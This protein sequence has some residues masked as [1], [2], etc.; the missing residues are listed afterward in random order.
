LNFDKS[1]GI[2][3]ITFTFPEE[4]NTPVSYTHEIETYLYEPNVSL[5]KAGFYKGI[6]HRYRLKKLHP[7]SHLYTSSELCADFPGRIFQVEAVSSLNRQEVK[8]Y[9]PAMEKANI[10]IRNFPLSVV[11]LRKKWKWKEGG[12]IYLFATTLANNKHVLIK[13][14]RIL[15]PV[16]QRGM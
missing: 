1:E 6:A 7:D 3:M 8:A 14:F 12:D 10:S 11:E 9:F 16:T 13:T 15:S 2:Q 5:L 4:K